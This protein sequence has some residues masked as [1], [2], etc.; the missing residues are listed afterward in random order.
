MTFVM[1]LK[2]KLISASSQSIH[3]V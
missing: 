2:Y 1:V 3:L